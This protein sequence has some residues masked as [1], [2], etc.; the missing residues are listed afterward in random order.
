[1]N[2]RD[3]T[4]KHAVVLGA[5]AI[6]VMVLVAYWPA[7]HAG[8]VWDDNDYV[9]ENPLLTAPDGLYR[10]WFT[11]DSPS[12]YF[13]LVYTTFR[14]EHALWGLN[15]LGYHVVNILLHCANALLLLLLLR[16][17]KIPGA[18]MAAAI[19]AL[20]P[21]NVESVAWITE[22]KNVLSTLFYLLAVG[23]WIRFIEVREQDRRTAYA[24]SLICCALALFA[25]TTACTIPGVLLIVLW[26]RKQPINPKRLAQVLPFAAAGIAMGLVSIWW[27]KTK[28]GTTGHEFIMAPLE[29]VLVAS[30]ALW[31]YLGK[32]FW[33]VDLM[34]SYPK[35]HITAHDMRQYVWVAASLVAVIALWRQRR[36]W[37]YWPLVAVTFFAAVL[38]PILG[39]IPLYTFIYSYVAD[40]YQYL[41][42][43]GPIALFAALLARLRRPRIVA[44]VICG[45]ILCMLGALTWRQTCTYQ[46]S[47]TLW[48]DVLAK[49]PESWAANEGVGMASAADGDL[50]VATAHF[51]RALELKPDHWQGWLNL[52]TMLAA[53]GQ[54][55]EAERSFRSGLRVN[56]TSGDLQCSLAQVLLAEGKW[57][58]A[59]R[60][61]EAVLR[62]YPGFFD[63]HMILA[64]VYAAHGRRREAIKHL[65]IAVKRMPDLQQARDKLEIL[66]AEERLGMPSE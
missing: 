38:S 27:E 42:C 44:Y 66:R 14:V 64:D 65:E 48:A 9:T 12:Q 58:E 30:R 33:P 3:K 49:N 43:V 4:Q 29:R 40:H 25:K 50:A 16:R 31:F 17:L 34:F 21:V 53:Q 37:G 1:M 62:Q 2:L 5:L 51:K 22:R 59:T 26:I 55:T 52:G 13:P 10:I 11:T 39:F 28:Q 6:A 61:Y 54:A 57:E 45:I 60:I 63:P 36:S 8:F 41:A 18:W 7:V 24:L 47:G 35:W 56:P 23:Q 32:L 15:P 19:W 20:H 46:D